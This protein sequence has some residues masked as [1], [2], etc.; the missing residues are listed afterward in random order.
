M[1]RENLDK[2]INNY[3]AS[4]DTIND[5]EHREYYKW[6]ALRHFKDN[7]DIDAP[8]FATMF[9]NATKM[10]FNLINNSI[11]QPTMGII[12]LAERPELTE[13]VRQMFKDLCSDDNGNIDLRQD[14]INRFICQCDQLLK[15]YEKGKWKYAQDI[16]SVIAYL[17]FIH[18]ERN[19]MFKS[20]EA[21]KFKDCVEFGHDF[22]RGE[23]FSLKKYYML[24]D[25]LVKEIKSNESFIEMH[26]ARLTDNMYADDDYH[27]LAYDIIYSAMYYNLYYNVEIK[28]PT[29]SGKPR[30]DTEQL[31][32]QQEEK[33]SK[34]ID[35]IQKHNDDLDLLFK[36]RAEYDSF[37]T[38]GL[39][40]KHKTF[41]EG[42]IS[43][44]DTQF[45]KIDF[46]GVEK[47]FFLPQGFTNGYLST[48]S[49]EAVET[50][51]KIAKLDKQIQDL[52]GTISNLSKQMESIG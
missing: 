17:A 34:L 51:L 18:P 23:A 40:V 13:T 9:K 43:Y 30:V 22:G 6:E 12:K 28:K 5:K 27:M 45:V 29:K 47:K 36:Q 46:D 14:K 19:Y 35:Q 41:G 26:N 15:T 44:Y 52:E 21:H 10:T 8:D 32:K 2:V 25:E 50:M 4:F 11:V 37:T 49:E 7:F 1:N 16:K 33:R 38:K 20:T 24:C 39:V 42:C 48:D 31:K 3:I